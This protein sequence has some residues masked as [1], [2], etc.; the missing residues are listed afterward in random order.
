MRSEAMCEALRQAKAEKRAQRKRRYQKLYMRER[1]KLLKEKRSTIEPSHPTLSREEILAVEEAIEYGRMRGSAHVFAPE[2]TP[3]P[4][5]TA[6]LAEFERQVGEHIKELGLQ[7]YGPAQ[8]EQ[9]TTLPPPFD[10]PNGII[11]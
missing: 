8:P 7:K 4:D 1:R 9:K 5:C 6:A 2:S 10:Y 11:R 3:R